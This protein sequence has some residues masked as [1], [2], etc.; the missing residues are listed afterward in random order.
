MCRNETQVSHHLHN[1][2][3]LPF[4]QNKFSGEIRFSAD[5]YRVEWLGKRAYVRGKALIKNG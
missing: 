3:L 5:V 2:C 1:K 4:S